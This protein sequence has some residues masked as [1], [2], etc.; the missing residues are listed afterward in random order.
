MEDK[1]LDSFFR[2]KLAKHEVKPRKEAWQRLESKMAPQTKGLPWLRYVAS[3]ALLIGAGYLA[4]E[5]LQSERGANHP[6]ITQLSEEPFEVPVIFPEIGENLLV[7][8]KTKVI[9][10][11]RPVKKQV[12]NTAPQPLESNARPEI[13]G[14]EVVEIPEP[15]FTVDFVAEAEVAGNE[16]LGSSA[17]PVAEAIEDS[18][19]IT[20]RIV[21]N[22]FAFVSEKPDLIEGIEGGIDKLGGIMAK[23]DK[24]FADLQDVKNNFFASVI[25]QKKD[26]KELPNK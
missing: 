23:V 1:Q 20:V 10:N 24:G 8:E 7:E 12:T 26:R 19:E 4:S 5:L 17:D 21:S 9:P 14:I 18:N 16:R 3:L 2:E 11:P 15:A 22:G 13:L 6:L 25:S